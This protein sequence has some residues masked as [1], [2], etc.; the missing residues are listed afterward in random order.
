MKIAYDS[1]LLLPPISQAISFLTDRAKI[2]L[3]DIQYDKAEGKVKIIMLRKKPI[4]FSKSI[5]GKIQPVYSQSTIK[6]LLIIRQVEE[7]SIKVDDRLVRDCNSDFTVLF[8]LRMDG[9]NLY[10]GS[11]EEAQGNLLCQIHIKVGRINLELY[12]VEEI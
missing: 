3:D 1:I 8:G 2:C 11:V 7:M 4:K 12:D 5:F 10:F 6:S 9:N